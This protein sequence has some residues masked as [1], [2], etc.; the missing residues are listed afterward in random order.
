MPTRILSLTG[1][2][3]RGIFQAVYLRE[4]ETQLSKP[5]RECFDLV[6]GTSTGAI[7]GLGVALGVDLNKIVQL[8]ESSGSSIFPPTIRKSANRTI[9][10]LRRGPRYDSEPLRRNLVEVFQADGTRQLQIK[11]C[12]P[13]VVIAAANLDRYQIRTFTTI[14]RSGPPDSRDGELFAADVAL[15]S[16]AAPLFFPAFRPRGRMQ[17]GQI[18]TEERT[19]VDGGLWANNPTLWAVM[20]AHRHMGV[21]FADMRVIS[22]GNGEVP[23]GTIGVDFNN[24]IRAKMLNP[25]LDIMF[26]TQSELSD[27]LTAYLLRDE[28]MAGERMLRINAQLETIVD[29]DNVTDAIQRL[30]P[31][32]EQVARSTFGR[33]SKLVQE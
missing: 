3:I 30:K 28:S 26:S 27:L 32:A 22:V 17:N 16:A 5:V 15:A 4:I 25:I 33:F 18:R 14:D 11:D 2:G 6:A 9:S 1:G 29:L 23:A 8:F 7:I 19:Y 12:R 24:L 21:A 10:W 13:P 31:L 20:Q